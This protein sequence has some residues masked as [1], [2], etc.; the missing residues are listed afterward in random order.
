M[1]RDS[2]WGFIWKCRVLAIKEPEE[3]Q[4]VPSELLRKYCIFLVAAATFSTSDLCSCHGRSES[5]KWRQHLGLGLVF[6]K[7]VL[8][9]HHTPSLLAW[10]Q[11]K[12]K[13]IAL[14]VVC[15]GVKEWQIKGVL[16]PS[17]PPSHSIGHCIYFYLTKQEADHLPL[18]LP[19]VQFP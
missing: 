6:T 4:E 2:F 1:K 12:E 10:P 8:G 16:P 5:Q 18:T 17:V 14:V 7:V 3:T 11:G 9:L 13:H 15:K 19:P